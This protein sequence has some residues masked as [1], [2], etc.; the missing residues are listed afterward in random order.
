MVRNT[1][2]SWHICMLFLYNPLYF[3]LTLQDKILY[4]RLE[5]VKAL[6]GQISGKN[7]TLLLGNYLFSKVFWILC[8][9]CPPSSYSEWQMNLVIVELTGP[10]IA[11]V[12]LLW[13]KMTV[14]WKL[15]RASLFISMLLFR[16]LF[17]VSTGFKW[18]K[19][20]IQLNLH[21]FQIELFL[22]HFEMRSYITAILAR[23]CTW[24]SD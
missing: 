1:I 13:H 12:E 4:I 22:P 20:Q 24:E 6:R 23:P 11:V 16:I 15:S 3:R 21:S 19:R 2:N 5:R 7:W 8:G 9:S 14:G 18:K 17:T 10:L